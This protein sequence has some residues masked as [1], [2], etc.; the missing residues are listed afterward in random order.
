MEGSVPPL[1]FLG[2]R[3]SLT[4]KLR[5][6]KCIYTYL[7]CFLR[8]KMFWN[9]LLALSPWETSQDGWHYI[10]MP[11]SST[12]STCF[13]QLSLGHALYRA[14]MTNSFP[15]SKGIMPL[16]QDTLDGITRGR[17][18]KWSWKPKYGLQ[19]TLTNTISWLISQ[20]RVD[21]P[22]LVCTHHRGIKDKT[23]FYLL[24][25][26]FKMFPGRLKKV[27]VVF[28]LIILYH[29][30][31]MSLLTPGSVICGHL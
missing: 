19:P 4:R 9:R 28:V 5:K 15:V 24:S 13:S 18:G 21:I 6:H 31:S 26:A 22:V 30:C 2:N 7:T 8:R 17:K 1:I 3:R 27:P 11:Y 10:C 12:I 20:R 25:C 14:S 23:D 29:R 16:S